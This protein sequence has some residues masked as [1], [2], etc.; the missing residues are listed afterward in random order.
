MSNKIAAVKHLEDEARKAIANP[1]FIPYIQLHEFEGLLFAH[2]RGFDYIHNIREQKRQ[3]IRDIIIGYPNPELINDGAETAPSK[4]LKG[5]I[6]RYK[7]TFHGPIIA[8]ENG[9]EPILE[10]CPRFSGWVRTII[11]AFT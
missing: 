2:E 4:R 7:K 1:N 3:V 8:L 5:L 9:L 11:D 6:P 10:K